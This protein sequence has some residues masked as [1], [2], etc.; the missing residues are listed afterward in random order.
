M[1][2][3]KG[4]WKFS[5]DESKSNRK[6]RNHHYTF[7]VNHNG[8]DINGFIVHHDKHGGK[9]E[10]KRVYLDSNENGRFDK[11]DLF[12]GS[13]GI[14]E[15]VT[16]KGAGL[17]RDELGHV[18]IQFKQTKNRSDMRDSMSPEFQP[19]FATRMGFHLPAPCGIVGPCEGWGN[20]VFDLDHPFPASL[21][22]PSLNL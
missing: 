17:D 15:K 16:R 7:D 2:T 12:L 10:K 4:T 5:S 22:L 20:K 8:I 11:D 13:T 1:P 6:H 19:I 14:N 18:E 9:K 21:D 3:A